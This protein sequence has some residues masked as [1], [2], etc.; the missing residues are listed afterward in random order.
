MLCKFGSGLA[1]IVLGQIFTI[2]G[3]P[4]PSRHSY[5][6]LGI[7]CRA[8]PCVRP[9]YVYS[10]NGRTHGYAPTV[11]FQ[12]EIDM[13]HLNDVLIIDVKCCNVNSIRNRIPACSRQ[14][15]CVI[16][17]AGG[18]FFLMRPNE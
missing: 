17:F 15:G 6:A 2:M 11:P 14:I 16:L 9:F 10:W 18:T 7:V 5:V 8:Y 4:S 13:I 1:G 12:T 3:S